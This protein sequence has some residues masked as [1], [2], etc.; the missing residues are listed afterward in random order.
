MPFIVEDAGDLD[1]RLDASSLALELEATLSQFKELEVGVLT[2]LESR[3]RL[4]GLHDV[5]AAVLDHLSLT[6]GRNLTPKATHRAVLPIVRRTFQ[7]P[8]VPL[9]LKRPTDRQNYTRGII[10]R[11]RNEEERVVDARE[12]LVQGPRKS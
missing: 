12:L 9:V 3:K 6:H 4:N 5:E 1:A 8:K 2:V 11:V 7:H 10:P